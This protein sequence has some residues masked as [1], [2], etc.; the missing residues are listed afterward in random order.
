MDI[1]QTL[2]FHFVDAGLH[3]TV[4]QSGGNLFSRMHLVRILNQVSG[5][6]ENQRISTLKNI[7]RRERIQLRR[8]LIQSSM[9]LPQLG[10]NRGSERTA[11]RLQLS[12]DESQSGAQIVMANACRRHVQ[13]PMP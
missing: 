5:G 7:G 12:A 6:V 13:S 9:P 10:P 11:P 4:C 8:K 1:N 3:R 2:A